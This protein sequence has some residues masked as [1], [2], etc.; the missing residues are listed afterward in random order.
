[1]RPQPPPM[2]VR[3]QADRHGEVLA[4]VT[5]A[6]GAQVRVRRRGRTWRCDDHGAPAT[7][8]HVHAVSAITDRGRNQP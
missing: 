7:C 4:F 2:T 1:M 3:V 8:Q 6:G 5:D